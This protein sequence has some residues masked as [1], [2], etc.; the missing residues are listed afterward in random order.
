MRRPLHHGLPLACG[1]RFGILNRN[2]RTEVA[3]DA[4]THPQR[5]PSHRKDPSMNPAHPHP[6]PRPDL[7]RPRRPPRARAARPWRSRLAAAS[8]ALLAATAVPAQAAA[9]YAEHWDGGLSTGGWLGNTPVAS[10]LASAEVGLP[11][12]SIA[13][14]FVPDGSANPAIGALSGQPPLRGDFHGQPWHVSFDVLRVHGPV[15]AFSLRYRIYDTPGAWRL[16]LALP[17]VGTWTHYAVSFDPA[18]SDEEAMA[19]GWVKE[20]H[21]WSW[22][23]SMGHVTQT[24]LLAEL[25]DDATT[26]LMHFDNFVQDHGGTLPTP[27]SALLAALALGALAWPRRAFRRLA[28]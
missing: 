19:A 6:D 21:A 3:A 9:V 2:G 25:A 5:L 20:L 27:S 14:V 7:Q 1:F 16:P 24:E 15:D 4:V 8:A 10:V 17:E 12:G 18:W 22:Q 23:S 11:P 28:G 26:A 13:S